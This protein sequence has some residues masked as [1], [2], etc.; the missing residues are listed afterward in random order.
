VKA[1]FSLD[2]SAQVSVPG[3]RN[4]LERRC[5]STLRSLSF[6]LSTP[7]V[8]IFLSSVEIIEPTVRYP[9]PVDGYDRTTAKAAGT[10]SSSTGRETF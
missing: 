10:S 6:I 9:S 8:K 5:A 4:S 2:R 1:E 7:V 3:A